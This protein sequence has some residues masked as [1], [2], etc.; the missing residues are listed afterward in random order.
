MPERAPSD[1]GRAR[2]ALAELAASLG[3]Q[4]VGDGASNMSQAVPVPAEEED[5]TATSAATHPDH[6]SPDMMTIALAWINA[7]RRR[8]AVFG[9][10]L[11]ADPAW[12]MLL[13]L[14]VNHCRGQRISISGLCL[15]TAAPSST[16]LRW[17]GVLEKR[18]LI[19]READPTDRRRSFV[20]LT[21]MSLHK[22]ED[23]LEQACESDR[24]L[25]LGRL[26]LIK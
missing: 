22:I 12:D 8:D 10:D 1:L 20:S 15:A 2:Q 26:R 23:A 14:Y 13:D 25:G 17:I 18:G 19:T 5:R 24:K 6:A 7:R 16:A 4:L 21:R 9:A 3:L 11:F